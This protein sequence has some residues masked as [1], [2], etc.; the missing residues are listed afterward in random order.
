MAHASLLAKLH[1]RFRDAKSKYDA[2]PPRSDRRAPL[3]RT[4]VNIN[5]RLIEMANREDRKREKA[6]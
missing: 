1:R 6:A 5:R 2:L 4:M 3:H